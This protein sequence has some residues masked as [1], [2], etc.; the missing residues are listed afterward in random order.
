MF[1]K[2]QQGNGGILTHGRY[3]LYISL[4]C[5]RLGL[6]QLRCVL[7]IIII[8]LLFNIQSFHI[9]AGD[10]SFTTGVCVYYNM[11]IN[12]DISG[13]YYVHKYLAPSYGITSQ[14]WYNC[15]D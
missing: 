10:I 13:L 9:V 6:I 5:S 14:L 2:A 3:S 4:E 15:P 12:E 11:T 1:T 8:C 7:H